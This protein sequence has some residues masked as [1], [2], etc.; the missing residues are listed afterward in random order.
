MKKKLFLSAALAAFVAL[1]AFADDLLPPPKF[2]ASYAFTGSFN[3]AAFNAHATA[4]NGCIITGQDTPGGTVT[5]ELT[6]NGTVL[7][8][9]QPL[10]FGCAVANLTDNTSTTDI[11]AAIEA[12]LRAKAS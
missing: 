2:P 4:V 3:A 7:I 10:G 5:F 8:P 6:S 12:Y 1:A 9:G 11:G